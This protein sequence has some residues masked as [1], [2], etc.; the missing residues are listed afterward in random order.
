L[1]PF[2]LN[3]PLEYA[4]SKVQENEDK[5]ELNGTN[6]LLI[7]VD[8]INILGENI[9]IVKKNT[10]SLVQANSKV[11][12]DVNAEQ[13]KYMFVSCRQSAGQNH[14]LLIANKSFENVAK[15]KYLGTTIRS[16]NCI[17]KELK[18]GLNS[19]NAYYDSV[20]SLL[21]SHLLSKNLN[22]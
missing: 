12:L 5:L 20:Q 8:N 11:G 19:G 15:F 6:Q 14:S 2:L 13:I 21:S 18:S 9:N 3:F 7:C 1:S 10:E 16:Q 4:I 17:H 22:V